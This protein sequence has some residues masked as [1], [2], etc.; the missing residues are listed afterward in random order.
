MGRCRASGCAATRSMKLPPSENP[1]EHHRHAVELRRQR[2]H[3]TDDFGQPAG[4][5]QLAVQMVRGAVIAQVEPHHFEVRGKQGLRE[6]QHVGGVRAAFPA[7]QQHREPLAG[8]APAF[9]G[10]GMKGLQRD[11]VA[12][13]EQQ[14]LAGGAHRDGAPLA[15]APA[16]AAAGQDG[17][18]VR[19]AQP[20]PGSKRGCRAGS[21]SL[22]LVEGLRRGSGGRGAATAGHGSRRCGGRLRGGRHDGCAAWPEPAPRRWCSR[23]A[24][25]GASPAGTTASGSAGRRSALRPARLT[26]GRARRVS[27]FRIGRLEIGAQRGDLA[28]LFHHSQ[29]ME[30]RAR[31]G[32]RAPASSRRWRTRSGARASAS[33]RQSRAR[34]VE[35][36]RPGR[37][38]NRS[39]C[40]SSELP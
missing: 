20:A 12:A 26:T 7:M 16:A 6:R 4:M 14:F 3:G 32:Q 27:S 21:R 30:P 24:A 17:L 39:V 23:R 15:R 36:A 13:I 11:A 18:E 1:A 22:R 37:D 25:S 2:A 5:K 33:V 10:A 34:A 28:A 9:R 31:H 29:P 38:C 19:A 40:E 8:F 35:P